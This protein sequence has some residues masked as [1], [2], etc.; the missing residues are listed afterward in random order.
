MFKI[1]LVEDAPDQRALIQMVFKDAD[2][3]YAID[4]ADSGT[5]GIEKGKN[6]NYDIILL[7][8]MLPGC[9]GMELLKKLRENGNKTPVLF[10]TAVKNATL[11][12]E[13]MRLGISDFILKE[14]AF[15]LLLPAVVKRI[16]D[17]IALEKRLKEVEEESRFQ[18]EKLANL[19][20]IL[21]EIL[22]E[23]RNPLSIIS[24]GLEALRD[25]KDKEKAVKLTLDLMLRNVDR[26][27]HTI[28]DLLDFSRP[29]KY[30]FEKADLRS[31]VEEI[32]KHLKLKCDRE[33]IALS[34]D[35]PPG[36]PPLTM[37]SQHIKG[38][39]LNLLL[40]AIEAMPYGGKLSVSISELGDKSGLRMDIADSGTGMDEETRRRLFE[41]N[42]TTKE[43]GTG[44]GLIITHQIIEQHQGTIDVD[45]AP[46]KGTTF[47][48]QLPFEHRA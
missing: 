31:T 44:L 14:G 29:K 25:A 27:R 15:Q 8:Y 48:I 21:S 45:S 19:G 30:A 23:L 7:D 26:T 41:R 12:I 5:A 28:N 22:H 40:N 35:S 42:F 4:E 20:K 38:A 9:S 36:L 43:H 13:A 33:H 10:M 34:L 1:L 32:L 18:A 37:D 24:T 16:L 11:T 39:L 17:K 46:G 6:G 47:T 3:V 2:D